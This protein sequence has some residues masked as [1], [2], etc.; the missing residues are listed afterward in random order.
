MKAINNG[1][2]L[3]DSK[4]TFKFQVDN[5]DSGLQA[6]INEPAFRRADFVQ[7]IESWKNDGQRVGD[8]TV[9]RHSK[10]S[11][12][13]TTD[14]EVTSVFSNSATHPA[15]LFIRWAEKA[16]AD[17]RRAEKSG[18]QCTFHA[19]TDNQAAEWFATFQKPAK[20]KARAVTVKPE[21]ATV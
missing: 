3:Q 18:W 10:A 6:M 17:K 12:A 16:T 19:I 21:A 20:G 8:A 4:G 1:L 15:Y 14:S 7:A 2:F 9:G 5:L 11:E 13:G